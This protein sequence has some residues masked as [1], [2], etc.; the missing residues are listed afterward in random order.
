VFEGIQQ[1]TVPQS[2]TYTIDVYGASSG[3]NNYG[4]NGYGAKMSGNFSLNS[5][6]VINILVGQQGDGKFGED[7]SYADNGA[8]GGGG[9]F[10]VYYQDDDPLIIAGGGGAYGYYADE[11]SPNADATAA[12]I[13]GSSS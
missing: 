2:G 7:L 12:M 9:T 5:G 10:V 1:W 6:D 8:G 11:Y 3:H 13:N 4:L